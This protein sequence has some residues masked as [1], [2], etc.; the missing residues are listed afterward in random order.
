MPISQIN[1]R[2]S[3]VFLSASFIEFAH[4]RVNQYSELTEETI[5]SIV[6]TLCEYHEISQ[7]LCRR[8]YEAIA[9]HVEKNIKVELEHMILQIMIKDCKDT[10]EDT[11]RLAANI[12]TWSI[13]GVTYRWNI[14]KRS[15]T[16]QQFAEKILPIL[17]GGF[18]D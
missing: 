18:L 10:D 8:N 1:L 2:L 12:L 5:Q 15:E 16:P 17:R 7:K 9:P 11:L 13:Y 6:I 4:K 3:T 14:E